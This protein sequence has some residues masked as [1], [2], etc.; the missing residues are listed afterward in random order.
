MWWAAISVPKIVGFGE[1]ATHNWRGRFRRRRSC[2]MGCRRMMSF[3]LVRSS[4]LLYL[5]V[6]PTH[7]LLLSPTSRGCGDRSI[8]TAYPSRCS[9][10]YGRRFRGYPTI[11]SSGEGSSSSSRDHRVLAGAEDTIHTLLI[12]NYDSYTYNLF[13]LL[14]VVNGQEPFVVYNDDCDGDLW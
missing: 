3:S 11:F 5:S 7:G 6:N 4:I 12:D 2:N 14:A 9:S 13:Q 8:V 10:S 1:T